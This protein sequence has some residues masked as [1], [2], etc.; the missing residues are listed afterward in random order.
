ML[1][2][3]AKKL[4]ADLAKTSDVSPGGPLAVGALTIAVPYDQ[5]R[6][7]DIDGIGTVTIDALG[8]MAGFSPVLQCKDRHGDVEWIPTHLVRN[9]R[10]EPFVTTERTT[11]RGKESK[12]S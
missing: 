4:R 9:L 7:G 5:L 3:F 1:A 12:A 8:N 10:L 11:A 6:Y 2:Q